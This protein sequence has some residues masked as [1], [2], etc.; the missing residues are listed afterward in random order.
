MSAS[1]QAGQFRQSGRR[2]LWLI[3]LEP[4][5]HIAPVQLEFGNLILFQEFDQLF[6]ILDIFWIQWIHSFLKSPT[7]G[8]DGLDHN[9]FKLR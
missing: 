8:R 9:G 6:Q 2:G 1:Q 3:E 7:R 4:D 5:P